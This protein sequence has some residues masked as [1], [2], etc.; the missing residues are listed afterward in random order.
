M[1]A[2]VF[3]VP[4]SIYNYIGNDYI[5]DKDTIDEINESESLSQF[6]VDNQVKRGDIVVLNP[7]DGYR[8]EYHLIYD[9]SQLCCLDYELYPAGTITVLRLIISC[10]LQSFQSGTG[11]ML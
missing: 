9:G 10:V 7:V 6:I 11:K 2:S 5:Y 1:E 3:Y 4:K 8:N